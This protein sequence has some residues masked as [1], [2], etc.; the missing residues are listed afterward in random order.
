MGNDPKAK[1]YPPNDSFKSN[2]TRSVSRSVSRGLAGTM[3]GEAN[4][5]PVLPTS[6]RST[7]F[8]SFVILNDLTRRRKTMIATPP[9]AKVAK[10]RAPLGLHD[11]PNRPLATP[12]TN[13]ARSVVDAV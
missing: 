13:L 5:S 9:L 7:R 1:S 4:S 3:Q 2:L 12:Q 8:H 6:S 11:P 10:E